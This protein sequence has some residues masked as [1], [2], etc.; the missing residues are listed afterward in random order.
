MVE[1]RIDEEL[2]KRIK[3]LIEKGENRFDFPTAKF[4]V[5]RAVLKMLKE[6]E[7]KEE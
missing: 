4:F 5:D 1:V 2:L 6:H 7:E 3:K